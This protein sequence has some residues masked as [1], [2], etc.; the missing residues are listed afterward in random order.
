M[1]ARS[2]GIDVA[3]ATRGQVRISRRFLMCAAQDVVPEGNRRSRRDAAVIATTE[4]FGYWLT[5]MRSAKRS[6]ATCR[7]VHPDIS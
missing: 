2:F 6:P 5:G 3:D 7:S 4:R 1:L